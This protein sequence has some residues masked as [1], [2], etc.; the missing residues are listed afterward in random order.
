VNWLAALIAI[1]AVGVQATADFERADVARVG[2]L[3]RSRKR[4]PTTE[5][6]PTLRSTK[7]LVFVSD[8]SANPSNPA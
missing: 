5:F 6:G 3:D 4:R 1:G 8:A 7:R 2:V